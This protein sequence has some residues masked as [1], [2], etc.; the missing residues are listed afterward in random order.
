MRWSALGCA[1]MRSAC[2]FLR[3]RES[4]RNR[5]MN[6]SSGSGSAS[7]LVDVLRRVKQ[8]RLMFG[9]LVPRVRS[10]SSGCFMASSIFSISLFATDV[11]TISRA[12]V[13]Y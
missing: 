5:A 4:D 10:Y 9:R 12:A 6:E 11:P 8:N 3:R 13:G 1:R 7:R 2:A